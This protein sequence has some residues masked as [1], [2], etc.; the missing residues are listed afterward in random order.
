MSYVVGTFL[1]L[2]VG[3]FAGA[4]F[5]TA[6]EIEPG[7]SAKENLATRKL[8][9]FTSQVLLALLVLAGLLALFY[10]PNSNVPDVQLTIV[11]NIA[12]EFQTI[13]R[14][15]TL[16]SLVALP[17][18]GLVFIWATIAFLDPKKPFG[19]VHAIKPTVAAIATLLVFEV[20][21]V[22]PSLLDFRL[23]HYRMVRHLAPKA[24]ESSPGSLSEYR[25]EFRPGDSTAAL[26]ALAIHGVRIDQH[27][28][29]P[30][31]SPLLPGQVPYDA[32]TSL[33][34]WGDR[35]D[36]PLFRAKVRDYLDRPDRAKA[37]QDARL[38][39]M[40]KMV[41]EFVGEY[42]AAFPVD[43]TR[44]R[45]L[46]AKA[47]QHLLSGDKSSAK[48]LL[49]EA[50]QVDPSNEEAAFLRAQIFVYIGDLDAA[51]SD[52]NL[53]VRGNSWAG[54]A[55]Y[56]RARIQVLRQNYI[57]AIEDLE[58]LAAL[59]THPEVK[60]AIAWLLA[61]AS[62]ER[63][64][65][66]ARAIEIVTKLLKEKRDVRALAVLCLSQVETSDLDGAK[67]S[68]REVCDAAS[69][70]Q[71]ELV[72]DR[73]TRAVALDEL[74]RGEWLPPVADEVF[75]GGVPSFLHDP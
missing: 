57:F 29:M 33:L 59:Q 9:H 1:A 71:E 41:D 16:L 44:S 51:L 66:P 37:A 11:D 48:K 61:T 73:L 31:L 35:A 13:E 43:T 39:P 32:T 50:L 8:W 67:V 18:V 46:V 7:N 27:S 36:L 5:H 26:F 54:A 6:S 63:I 53:A 24:G 55:I 15:E 60:L 56:L 22:T 58:V 2:I 4:M 3:F 30:L 25:G 19:V 40:L 23:E 45:S 68:M 17:I 52:A 70:E 14:R 34:Q 47:E 42:N 64:R 74:W 62:D 38:A 20:M 21:F 10:L 69:D 75:F 28:F 65:D 12:K 49:D 72:C